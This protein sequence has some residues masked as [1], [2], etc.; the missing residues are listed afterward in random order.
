M[1]RRSAAKPWRETAPPPHCFF[2]S[3]NFGGTEEK[4]RYAVE[5]TAPPTALLPLIVDDMSLD[6][7]GGE[8]SGKSW[9]TMVKFSPHDTLQGTRSTDDFTHR[10]SHTSLIYFLISICFDL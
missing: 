8:F 7:S 3:E 6:M 2:V 4:R 10:R 5:G 1:D 9:G